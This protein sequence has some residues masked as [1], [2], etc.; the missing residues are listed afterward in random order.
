MQIKNLASLMEMIQKL[1][2]T[3]GSGDDTVCS[4]VEV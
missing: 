4:H 3:S 2:E 1:T